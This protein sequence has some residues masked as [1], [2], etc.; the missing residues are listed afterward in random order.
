M[1]ELFLSNNNQKW[2]WSLVASGVIFSMLF[3][4]VHSVH[5]ALL[6]ENLISFNIRKFSTYFYNYHVCCFF[7][8]ETEIVLLS[9]H[10]RYFEELRYFSTGTNIATLPGLSQSCLNAINKFKIHKFLTMTEMYWDWN[11]FLWLVRPKGKLK[12]QFLTNCYF[13][14]LKV[15]NNLKK[16]Y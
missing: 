2:L 12:L 7:F 14:K 5:S 15:F 11:W 10:C 13:M 8:S 9:N 6:N 4:T 3:L 1:Q 16:Q